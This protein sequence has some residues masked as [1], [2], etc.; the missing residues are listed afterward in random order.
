MN[1]RASGITINNGGNANNNN[2]LMYAS[3]TGTDTK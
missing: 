2:N 1:T 3:R